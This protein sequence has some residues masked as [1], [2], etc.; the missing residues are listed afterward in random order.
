MRVRVRVMRHGGRRLDDRAMVS[1][2]G[3]IGE[4]TMSERL[5]SRHG[6]WRVV[7]LRDP[8]N[9]VS[10]PLLPD[11][12]DPILVQISH[13]GIRLRGIERINTPD[14]TIAV[15]QEWLCDLT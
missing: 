6:A 8:G 13:N 14:A 7:S 4:L 11:L 3:V 15:V 9:H 5:S 10:A 2:P 12:L 1:A